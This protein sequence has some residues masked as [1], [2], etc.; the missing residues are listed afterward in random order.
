MMTAFRAAIGAG[1][2][3]PELPAA[4]RSGL[5]ILRFVPASPFTQAFCAPV[6]LDP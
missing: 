2:P 5:V 1:I 4:L 3:G 6:T